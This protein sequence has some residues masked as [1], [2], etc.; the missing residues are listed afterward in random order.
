[1]SVILL[2]AMFAVAL[3]AWG[4]GNHLEFAERVHRRRRELLPS[5]VAKLLG[6]HKRPYLYGNIAADIINFKNFGGHYNHCHRWTIVDDMRARA[7]TAWNRSMRAGPARGSERIRA[8]AV[9]RAANQLWIKVGWLIRNG[10]MPCP[11][12]LPIPR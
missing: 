2:L 10:A 6:E 3:L 5:S 12:A 4:P 1:M 9:S 7:R 8:R 11:V